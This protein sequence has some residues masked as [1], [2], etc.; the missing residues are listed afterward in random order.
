M[1]FCYSA[2]L[3]QSNAPLTLSTPGISV[4]EVFA[5]IAGVFKNQFF[6]V[7]VRLADASCA[8]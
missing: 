7:S 3:G 5:L 2:A 1:F 6:V 8:W 4:L